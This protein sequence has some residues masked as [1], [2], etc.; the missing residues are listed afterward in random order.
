[1]LQ[2]VETLHPVVSTFILL[3]QEAYPV[4]EAYVIILEIPLIT[5]Y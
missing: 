5:S 3:L 2:N 1:M 4:N